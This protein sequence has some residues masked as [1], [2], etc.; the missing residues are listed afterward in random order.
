MGTDVIS[1]FLRI[2][3]EQ[4]LPVVLAGGVAA[5]LYGSRRVTMDVD[6]IPS[7]RGR[8]WKRILET[9]R[10]LG[11]S[12]VGAKWIE[13]ENVTRLI[14]WARPRDVI[15]LRF[16]R[17][18]PPLDVDLLFIEGDRYQEYATRAVVA[19]DDA[20]TLRILAREDLLAMKR[21]AGRPQDLQDIDAMTDK[22]N[23]VDR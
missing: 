22:D 10:A 23:S 2:C 7:L 18:T 11:F 9:L 19:R 4:D 20:L 3:S 17:E 12:P 5:Q 6:L 8:D 16:R 15:S 13:I 14:K 21:R 1:E